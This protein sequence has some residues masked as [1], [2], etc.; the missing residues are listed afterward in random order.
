MTTESI[1]VRRFSL[2]IASAGLCLCFGT[3]GCTTT[4]VTSLHASAGEQLGQ[5]PE[6]KGIVGQM[7]RDGAITRDCAKKAGSGQPVVV[8]E[9]R[10]LSRDG[11]PEYIV[12]G[13]PGCA[14][15]GARRCAQWIYQKTP[16]G[17]RQLL[18]AVQPDEGISVLSSV[19]KGYADLESVGWSGDQ[20][21][22]EVYRFNG[23]KYVSSGLKPL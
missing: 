11:Q 17:Y 23:S 20:A 16:A 9:R 1:K 6:Y 14:C 22:R 18:D 8:I 2:L 3:F 4:T 5:S 10:D 21:L 15:I 19:T 13:E 12:S 7:A